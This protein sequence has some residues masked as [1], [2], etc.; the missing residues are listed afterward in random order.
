MGYYN[1]NES[2]LRR[3]YVR[4]LHPFTFHYAGKV[5]KGVNFSPEGF[6]VEAKCIEKGRFAFTRFQQL[7]DCAIEIEGHTIL[8]PSLKVCWLE[9]VEKNIIF[10]MLLDYATAPAKQKLLEIY[11]TLK[12]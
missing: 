12:G 1:S 6:G 2:L 11:E 8:L 9:E 7:K 10:G 4:V 5:Y 3:N